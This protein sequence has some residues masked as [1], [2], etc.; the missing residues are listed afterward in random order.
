MGLLD[1]RVCA[2]S[3]SSKPRNGQI[4]RLDAVFNTTVLSPSG[5]RSERVGLLSKVKADM[6]SSGVLR[7]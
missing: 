2:L 3:V 7:G 4:F 6:M 1:P 5:M